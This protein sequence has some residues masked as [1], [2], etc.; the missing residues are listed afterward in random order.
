MINKFINR[1]SLLGLTFHL[2][3]LGHL[4]VTLEIVWACSEIYKNDSET[5]FECG[6]GVQNDTILIYSRL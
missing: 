1:W 5:L 2:P 6:F 4:F 3:E